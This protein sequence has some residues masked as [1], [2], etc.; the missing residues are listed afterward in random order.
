VQKRNVTAGKIDCQGIAEA[1]AAVLFTVGAVV[2]AGAD[3]GAGAGLG[4]IAATGVDVRA[5]VGTGAVVVVVTSSCLADIDL[6]TL[7]SISPSAR[8]GSGAKVF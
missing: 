8:W 1:P 3:A 5:A 2:G 7:E 4:A 6:W